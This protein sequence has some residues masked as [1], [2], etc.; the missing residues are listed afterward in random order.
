MD[1]NLC[2]FGSEM[3]FFGN[4]THCAMVEIYLGFSLEKEEEEET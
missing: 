2:I 3:V 4:L 1:L